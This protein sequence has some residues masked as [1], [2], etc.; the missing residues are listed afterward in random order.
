VTPLQACLG[1]A[2]SQQ[3]IGRVVVGVDNKKQLQEILAAAELEVPLPPDF[4]QSDDLD[5]INPSRW[6]ML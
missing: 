1:F 2:L 5:L 3:E 4:L 6:D